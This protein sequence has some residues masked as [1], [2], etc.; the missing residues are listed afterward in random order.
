ML[1]HSVVSDSLWPFG[2]QPT[3]LLCPWDFLGKNTGVGCDFLLQGIF[4]TQGSN[5]LLLCLLHCRQFLYPLSH[6]ESPLTSI[7]TS[8]LC[9]A[10]KNQISLSTYIQNPGS[11]HVSVG[12]QSWLWKE[13]S[14]LDVLVGPGRLTCHYFDLKMYLLI[15]NGINIPL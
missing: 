1:S 14:G 8:I 4:P 13:T 12:A 15:D 6:Q 11:K 10:N 3:R 9:M 5:H 2:L 7:R